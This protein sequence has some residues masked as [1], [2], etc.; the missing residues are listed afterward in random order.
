MTTDYKTGVEA[1]R[2]LLADYDRVVAERDSLLA[3][4]AEHRSC[5]CVER[6]RYDRGDV[7]RCPKHGLPWLVGEPK[8][9]E[10]TGNAE[11]AR[12]S[13]GQAAS[14]EGRPEC[15]APT[16]AASSSRAD[17]PPSPG[18]KGR[19]RGRA[20]AT[21][22]AMNDIRIKLEFLVYADNGFDGTA[23]AN[24]AAILRLGEMVALDCLRRLSDRRGTDSESG[25]TRPG[26][27]VHVSC[28]R[29]PREDLA[30]R[31]VPKKRRGGR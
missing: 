23:C 21:G 20:E 31:Q 1:L 28:A 6:G 5:E 29:P 11:T 9:S 26:A 24:P 12:A 25:G 14:S 18:P 4:L 3:Q 16:P 15:T 13:S 17:A 30:D 2:S 27:S 10:S 22:G 7:D 19:H 8:T